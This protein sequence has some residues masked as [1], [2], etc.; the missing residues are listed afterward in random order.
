MKKSTILF[1]ALVYIISFL[2]VGL[3]GIAVKGY[4][5][6]IYVD[7]IKIVVPEQGVTITDK[8]DYEAETIEYSFA[9][10][11]KAGLIVQLKA[12]VLPAETSF[13]EISVVYDMEQSAYTVDVV[14][15]YYIHVAFNKKA[16]CRFA[17]QSTDG[18]K[19]QVPVK[20]IAA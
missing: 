5:E 7:D 2:V 14:D 4:H 13:P 11:Y 9:T 3:F 17:V 20:I 10:K 16:S 8:T 19:Y 18:N 1:V 12:E 15:G 6:V